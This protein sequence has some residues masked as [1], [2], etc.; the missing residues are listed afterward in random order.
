M[1]DCKK[2][3]IFFLIP[4]QVSFP[5]KKWT[6]FGDPLPDFCDLEQ[7]R[8]EQI[9]YMVLWLN[10][11]DKE[12]LALRNNFRVTKKFLFIRFYCTR[13]FTMTFFD[14]MIVPMPTRTWFPRNF[15]KIIFLLL[16]LY[17]KVSN[18]LTKI[19][20]KCKINLSRKNMGIGNKLIQ[21]FKLGSVAGP[22][23]QANGRLTFEDDLRSGGLLYF[24]TQ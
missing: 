22:V 17:T 20:A 12:Y 23:I 13:Q 1:I 19:V 4:H 18:V 24:T 3:T 5:S 11:F 2:E 16:Y 21:S 7:N 9:P 15:A 6:F 14:S 10:T 8:I